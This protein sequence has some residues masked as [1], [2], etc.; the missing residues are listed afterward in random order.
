MYVAMPVVTLL[1]WLY[2]RAFSRSPGR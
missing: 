2:L 1:R